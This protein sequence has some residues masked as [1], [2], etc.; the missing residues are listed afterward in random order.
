LQI[1]KAKKTRQKPERY[2]RAGKTDRDNGSTQQSLLSFL[3]KESR[4]EHCLKQ[5]R[6]QEQAGLQKS[7]FRIDGV[8][9]QKA[10]PAKGLQILFRAAR[11]LERGRKVRAGAP[12]NPRKRETRGRRRAGEVR[13]A[14]LQPS[15]RAFSVARLFCA[16]P[17]EEGALIGV[18]V[19]DLALEWT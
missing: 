15:E 10:R 6:A 16:L 3:C 14:W 7:G 13:L 9:L 1:P 4:T 17:L 18:S 5:G 8:P 11:A 19:D 12:F 2:V